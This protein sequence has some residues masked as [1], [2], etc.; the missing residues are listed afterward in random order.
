MT[1]D[2]DIKEIKSDVKELK[3]RKRWGLY[4]I[5]FIAMVNSCDANDNTK[6]IKHKL[7]MQ[8]NQQRTAQIKCSQVQVRDVIGSKKPETFYIINGERVY[9]KIDGKPVDEYFKLAEEPEQ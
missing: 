9:L 1:I 4:L 8:E 6:Y 7:D 3:E 5:A 2:K